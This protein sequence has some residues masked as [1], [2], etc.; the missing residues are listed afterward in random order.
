MRLTVTLQTVARA[1]ATVVA[2]T[3]LATTASAQESHRDGVWFSM[4]AGA[5][6][7]LS[8]PDDET[9]TGFSGYIRAGGTP[10]PRFLV[11]GEVRFWARSVAEDTWVSRGNGTVNLLFYPSFD[12]DLL[13]NIGIGVAGVELYSTQG[14]TVTKEWQTGFGGTLG[15]GYDIRITDNFSITPNVDFLYQL[16]SDT[17]NYMLMLT[18]GAT[19]H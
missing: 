2:L 5:G 15:V 12:L 19:F 18:V 11:G 14:S 10:N 17:D 1:I 8:G 6:W 3:A 7:N 13:L 9:T 4:G 16:I